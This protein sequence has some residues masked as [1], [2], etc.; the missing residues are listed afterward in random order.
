MGTKVFFQFTITKI[1][2]V[3]YFRSIWIPILWFYGHYH[4]FNSSSA[5]IVFRRHHLQSTDVRLIIL[6]STY[7]RFWRLKTA[8]ALKGLKWLTHGHFNPLSP[9]DALKHHFTSLKTHL[10]FRQ[11]RVLEYLFLWN[12][13]TNTWQF[14][15][16]FKPHQIIFIHYKSKIATA[17]LGL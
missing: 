12:W 15:L 2:L 13:F 1:V 3:S 8:T 4:F 9:H 11:P 5:D 17:I 16:I 7:V 14:S 6:A 10:I